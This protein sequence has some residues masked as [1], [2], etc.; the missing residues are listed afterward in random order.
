MYCLSCG[1]VLLG[2]SEGRCPECGRPFDPDNVC[3]FRRFPRGESRG[4][5]VLA[6][7]WLLVSGI[8][9]MLFIVGFLGFMSPW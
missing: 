5:V 4:L 7:G 9:I 1:Y 2:L 3:T 8:V 6:Y